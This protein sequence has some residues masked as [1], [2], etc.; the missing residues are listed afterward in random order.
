MSSEGIGPLPAGKV[1]LAYRLTFQ[2]MDRV[3]VED[4]VNRLREKKIVPAL[5]RELGATIRAR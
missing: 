4:E 1:S 3:L 5:E 2:S